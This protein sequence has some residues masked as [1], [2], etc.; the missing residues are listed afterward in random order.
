MEGIGSQGFEIKEVGQGDSN[1]I[2]STHWKWGAGHHILAL[3]DSL[4]LLHETKSSL[5]CQSSSA[6][7][8]VTV[9][10]FQNFFDLPECQ[11]FP[12]V[13]NSFKCYRHDGIRSQCFHTISERQSYHCLSFK[14]HSFKSSNETWKRH[15]LWIPFKN[16]GQIF[17]IPIYVIHQVNYK[18]L[19]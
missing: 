15:L 2:K 17:L 4:A 8:Q 10:P 3:L 16:S 14:S 11:Q 13:G 1:N 19:L 12:L 9:S 6:A 18:Y 5:R 7:S